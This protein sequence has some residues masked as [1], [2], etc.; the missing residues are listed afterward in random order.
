MDGRISADME[1]FLEVLETLKFPKCGQDF[2]NPRAL[3]AAAC[4][5]KGSGSAQ[6]NYH[7]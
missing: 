5:P 4:Q 1:E 7:D 6:L 3:C 2:R